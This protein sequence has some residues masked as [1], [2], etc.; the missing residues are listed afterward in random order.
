MPGP[1]LPG[2][3]ESGFRGRMRGRRPC[4]AGRIRLRGRRPADAPKRGASP[5]KAFFAD[6]LPDSGEKEK[7]PAVHSLIW[8]VINPVKS[9]RR[10]TGRG[11]LFLVVKGRFSVAN[12]KA[13]RSID[14]MLRERSLRSFLF[15]DIMETTWEGTLVQSA[16][17]NAVRRQAGCFSPHRSGCSRR[18]VVPVSKK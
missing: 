5:E 11:F 15:Y 4:G 13:V 1:S 3:A 8:C 17:R 18:G 9:S 7:A 10:R 14:A 16:G 12:G 2:D 6:I